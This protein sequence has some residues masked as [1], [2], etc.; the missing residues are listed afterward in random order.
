MSGEG[1][2]ESKGD[3]ADM[4]QT[5]A[6]TP[7]PW[8][9][10][11]FSCCAR[12][13]WCLVGFLAPCWIVGRNAEHY[14]EDCLLTALLYWVGVRGYGPLLR[15]K[16]RQHKNIEGTITSDVLTHLCCPF[17]A[18]LQEFN[19]VEDDKISEDTP[20]IERS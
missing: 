19:E 14:G 2:V 3:A 20:I 7:R 16:L 13:K 10:G 1:V 17:C 11:L 4:V 5:A 12:P 6:A 15:H 9:N 18:A 8:R